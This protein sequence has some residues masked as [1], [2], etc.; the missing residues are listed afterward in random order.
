MEI[1]SLQKQ[2]IS[3]LARKF[4]LKL[5]LLFGSQVSQKIHKGSDIDL[6][7]L[8]EEEL[9]F[10]QE[11]LLNTNFCGIFKTD[12]V[13]TVNLKVAPPLLAEQIINNSKILYEREK[14][15]FDK[16]EIHVLRMFEEAK[17]IF[18]IVDEKLK[19][20]ISK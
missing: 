10:E 9:T 17:P 8:P 13:D 12:R 16:L 1:T 5:V 4:N 14:G 6:A 3:K 15:S 18:K 20:L 7:F 2:K 19:N 11:N